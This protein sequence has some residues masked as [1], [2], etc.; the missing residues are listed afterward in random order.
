MEYMDEDEE[1]MDECEISSQDFNMAF[2]QAM[3]DHKKAYPQGW[4]QMFEEFKNC[5]AKTDKPF[6]AWAMF[7]KRTVKHVN[8]KG[9]FVKP[10]D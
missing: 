9:N 3:N 1:L 10:K 4:Q 7:Q 2:V 6:D 8:K 5:M